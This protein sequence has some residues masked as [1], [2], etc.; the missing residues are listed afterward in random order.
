MYS[1]GATRSSKRRRGGRSSSSRSPWLLVVDLNGPTAST[2]ASQ[3]NPRS[4]LVWGRD[5]H[6]VRLVAA[7]ALTGTARRRGAPRLL[8]CRRS[9]RLADAV[10]SAF[11]WAQ[12]KARLWHS[13]CCSPPMVRDARRRRA[14]VLVALRHQRERHAACRLLAVSLILRSVLLFADSRHHASI[15]ARAR[16]DLTL[17]AI[18]AS[19]GRRVVAGIVLPLLSISCARRL[20]VG[21]VSR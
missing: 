21:A 10:Y 2:S 3:G 12:G 11:V 16:R 17:A 18:A 9:S 14:L 19:L 4:W 1:R 8:L 7:C 6:G 13:R 5:P 20:L 15:D